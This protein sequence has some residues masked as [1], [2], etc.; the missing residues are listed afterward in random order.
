MPFGNYILDF[1]CADARLAI[2]L[3]GS[4]HYTEEG[5]TKDKERDAFL[6]DHGMPVLHYTNNEINT[7]FLGV[8][9]SI[10]MHIDER[11]W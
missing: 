6:A 11:K 2:E 1:F 8:C 4:Q 3:D 10:Q 7:N 9:R 5:R